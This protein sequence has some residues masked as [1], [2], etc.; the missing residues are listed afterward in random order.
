MSQFTRQAIDSL[1]KQAPVEEEPPK[2]MPKK[3]GNDSKQ[4]AAANQLKKE[5]GA[6]T[7]GPVFK[8]NRQNLLDYYHYY[9]P[10]MVKMVDMVLNQESPHKHLAQMMQDK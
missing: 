7:A 3:E 2:K 5:D 8:L 10:L 1:P 4:P 9:N 6:L